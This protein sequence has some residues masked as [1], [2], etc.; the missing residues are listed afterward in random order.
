M[1]CD[2]SNSIEEGYRHDETKVIAFRLRFLKIEPEALWVNF[3]T[4]Y[5]ESPNPRKSFKDN[6]KLK[7]VFKPSIFLESS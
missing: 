3:I 2:N 1:S 4:H 7:W 5:D 6:E